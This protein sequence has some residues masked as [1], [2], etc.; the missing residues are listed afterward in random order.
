[1][2]REVIVRLNALNEAVGYLSK[3]P[4]REVVDIIQ[5]LKESVR[6]IDYEKE[7]EKKTSDGISEAEQKPK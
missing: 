7:E 5:N 3:C 4:Y 6:E 1:M 2:K